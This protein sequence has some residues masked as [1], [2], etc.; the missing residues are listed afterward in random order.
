MLDPAQHAAT[1]AYPKRSRNALN[2]KGKGKPISW[3]DY[4]PYTNVLWLAYLYEY[5]TSHF[6]GEDPRELEDFLRETAELRTH[7]DPKAPPRVLS[8][9]CAGEVIRFAVEAG[10]VGEDQLVGDMDGSW[11]E[12]NSRVG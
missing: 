7:L 6:R 5:L 3:R 1:G 12:G 9:P 8:F 2:G 10:W 4:H 11:L